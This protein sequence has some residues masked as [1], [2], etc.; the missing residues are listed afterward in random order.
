MSNSCTTD[1][2]VDELEFTWIINHFA[3]HVIKAKALQSLPFSS[4]TNKEFKWILTLELDKLVPNEKDD[5]P[6]Y[7]YLISR[8]KKAI[9]RLSFTAYG[10]QH[11]KL[12]R[13]ARDIIAYDGTS[14]T[15]W[16]W[17]RFLKYDQNIK[18]SLTEDKLTIVCK[19][20]FSEMNEVSETSQR[21]E[22]EVPKCNTLSEDFESLLKNQELV[23]V[24]LYVINKDYPAHK[25]ILAAR[26]PVFAAMF[27]HKTTENEENRVI[28]KDIGEDVMDEMLRYIYT[29]KCENVD[30]MAYELM[31]AADKYALDGLK[32][33]CG[34]ALCK[35]LTVENASNILVLAD[36]RGM[37][38][39]KT[40]V[41]T[42]IS[43]NFAKVLDTETWKN[44]LAAYPELVNEVC[45]GVASR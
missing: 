13:T 3:F 9:A 28:I 37:K 10:D 31:E 8:S 34:E 16:G 42:F 43:S 44:I 12:I 22:P 38:D 32:M 11:K 33:I 15:N 17:K 4:V 27:R 21:C 29:G 14:V 5:I 18:N 25:S 39:L 24:K 35:T 7:L 20:E 1:I 23:D 41:I 2:R 36:L 19:V 30:N 26:S 40:K 6:L 45:K